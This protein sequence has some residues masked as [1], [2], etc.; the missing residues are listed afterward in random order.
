[1]VFTHDTWLQRAFTNQELPV[2]VLEVEREARS[3]V[4]VR[5]VTDPVGQALDDARALARTPNLPP[6]AM[7]HVLPSLCRTVLERAF[8]EAAWLRLHRDGLTEHEAEKTVTTAVRLMDISALGLFGDPARTGDV[9][10]ELRRRCG[11]GAVD[12]IR[13]CQEGAHPSG[14]SMR[15]ARRFVDDIQAV[16]Q[17]VRKP[18][19]ATP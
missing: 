3:A 12:L 4:T 6:V 16:A 8:S 11:P 7:T 19:E 14:T 2:T 9:Y 15:D 13:Q 18:E 1:M 17:T 10:R 5:R